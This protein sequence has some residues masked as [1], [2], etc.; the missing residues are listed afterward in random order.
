M[1][2]IDQTHIYKKYKGLWVILDDSRTKV[3]TADPNLRNAVKK[4]RT[5]YGES[6]VP[7]SFKVP[8]KLMP[9]IGPHVKMVNIH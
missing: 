4:F 1:E 3:L 5:K 6:R 9:F 8:A 2:V 7:L